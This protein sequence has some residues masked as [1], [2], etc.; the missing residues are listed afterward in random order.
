MAGTLRIQ[1][2]GFNVITRKVGGWT[3]KRL[4]FC[5]TFGM[6]IE[7][8]NPEIDPKPEPLRLEIQGCLAFLSKAGELRWTPPQVRN[9]S[10][11]N[12]V[13]IL[14]PELHER[15]RRILS[16]SKFVKLLTVEYPSKMIPAK[17]IDPDVPEVMD[18]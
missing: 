9:G 14:S 11:Y 17:E 15:I 13:I 2:N 18:V 5:I 4:R 12:N 10:W 3:G 1:L 16:E 6:D 8:A 7:P